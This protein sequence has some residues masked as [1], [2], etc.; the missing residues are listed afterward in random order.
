MTIALIYGGE[1][2]EHSVSMLGFQHLFPILERNYR[3][4]PIF[5]DTCGV[6]WLKNRRVF[7]TYKGF[8][9]E[10]GCHFAV[11][12]AFPLLHGDMGEDGVVQNALT[13]AKI[14]YIGCLG[15]VG[16]IC[17]D[18]YVVKAVARSLS[19]PTLPCTLIRRGEETY[20]LTLP[21]FIK[22]CG[23]GSSVGAM[24]ARDEK[25]LKRALENAFRYTDR[26]I[27]EPYLENKREL[28][29]GY[30]SVKGKELFTNAGEILSNGSF[31]D[32]ESKYGG[33]TRTA[34]VADILPEIND[35]IKEYSARLVSALGVRHLSRID[36]FLSGDNL[37]FN[38]INTMPGFT[39]ECLY[40]RMLLT[41]GIDIPE[42]LDL[43][44]GD[45]L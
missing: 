4:L 39:A 14:P 12:C 37:Y 41:S 44:I 33:G 22:P 29:C 9:S 32:Y 36:F 24:A 10:D 5:I 16:A 34:T 23:L 13:L 15:P 45:A 42:M 19:I 27:A 26:V 17:R 2:Y 38:E 31:Y 43:L 18:K 8:C 6:F 1:G 25:E 35:K 20:D 7:P 30:F 3:V 40:P 21:V 28:E 11:D